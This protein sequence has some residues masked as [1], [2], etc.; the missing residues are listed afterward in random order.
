MIKIESL[1]KTYGDNEV[2][3]GIS[4]E[5]KAGEIVAVIGPSGTGKSTFLRC[6]N[7]L[8]R[9][10]SGTLLIGDVRVDFE[11]IS[12]DEV[13]SLRKKTSMVFQNYNL[14]KNKTALE[15]VMEALRVVKKMPKDEA[16]KVS[17]E[18]LKQVG[19]LDKANSYPSRLSGGQQ[20]RIGIARAM[21]LKPEIILFDEPTSAL[22]P[23][24]VGEVLDVIKG[25]ASRHLTMIIVTHEMSFAR[26]IA[27][28]IVFLDGGKIIQYGTPEEVFE[29]SNNDRVNQFIKKLH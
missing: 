19:L 23:E 1:H 10:D 4:L 22:D 27:D 15:N 9:P 3:K 18:A 13:Y 29:K 20:Q 2:L 11:N 5:I 21:V 26:E 8:E 28:K 17:L 25:I 24:W 16:E 7:Y 6:L 12:K 14:F